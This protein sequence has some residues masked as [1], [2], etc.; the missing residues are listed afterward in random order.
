MF[1]G[2]HLLK[3]WLGHSTCTGSNKY[4]REHPLRTTLDPSSLCYLPR[5]FAP[6]RLQFTQEESCL[7]INSLKETLQKSSKQRSFNTLDFT[8]LPNKILKRLNQKLFAESVFDLLILR[9]LPSKKSKTQVLVVSLKRWSMTVSL[10]CDL[11][12]PTLNH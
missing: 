4:M 5:L 1:S 10:P 11:T 2:S 12:R 6:M 9:Y 8:L 3:I 7:K